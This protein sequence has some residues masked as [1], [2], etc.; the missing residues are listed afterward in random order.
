MHK[1][2]EITLLEGEVPLGI[3]CLI[4]EGRFCRHTG[5]AELQSWIPPLIFLKQ[6]VPVVIVSSP[7]ATSELFLK[8]CPV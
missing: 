5:C 1:S 4:E 3:R 7:V 2:N 6:P 8:S